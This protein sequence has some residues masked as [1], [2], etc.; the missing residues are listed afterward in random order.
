MEAVVSLN[1]G[2]PTLPYIIPV[3]ISFSI[4]FSICFS[5]IVGPPNFG[6]PPK[7]GLV[8]SRE[9]SHRLEGM[10]DEYTSILQAAIIYKLA[11]LK[12]WIT[13]KD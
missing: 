12:P 7:V 8:W 13:P 9:M 11:P 6:K 10:E 2:T 1:R 4:F 5:I 3:S